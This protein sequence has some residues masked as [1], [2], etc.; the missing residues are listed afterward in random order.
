M[1]GGPLVNKAWAVVLF[2]RGWV[3]ADIT[4]KWSDLGLNVN[5]SYVVRDLWKEANI[6]TFTG[7]YTA[8]FLLPG[9]SAVLKLSPA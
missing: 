2:N 3:P 6:G 5:K 1:W 4:L 8:T 7:S 9:G